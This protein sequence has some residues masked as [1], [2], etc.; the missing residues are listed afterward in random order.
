MCKFFLDDL[1]TDI[2]EI[3]FLDV[4]NNN[5]NEKAHEVC[6]HFLLCMIIFTFCFHKSTNWRSGSVANLS[7]ILIKIF[8]FQKWN[9]IHKITY[10]EQ[11]FTLHFFQILPFKDFSL[12]NHN[13]S[14]TILEIKL[15]NFS[16][17]C[18]TYPLTTLVKVVLSK[19]PPKIGFQSINWRPLNYIRT[20]VDKKNRLS[21][22]SFRIL[23]FVF[24]IHTIG[25]HDAIV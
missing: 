23:D 9:F 14:Y 15:Q 5:E 3:I 17:N 1:N 18:I 8:D 24:T 4:N 21:F 25:Q 16:L 2:I 6:L 19:F 20:T 13:L 7:L 10:S 11:H 12:V 22:F